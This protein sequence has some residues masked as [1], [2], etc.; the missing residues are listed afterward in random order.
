MYIDFNT[1]KIKNFLSYGDVTIDLKNKGY[2]IIDGINNCL[3]DN[4]ENNGSGKSAITGAISFAL[5]G[6]TIQ[7]L[8]SNLKN[9][10]IDDNECFV[11]LDFKVDNNHYQIKRSK[12]PKSEL[13]II[14]ND[15][16]ISGKGIRESDQIL[17]LELP[18]LTSQTLASIA[19][20]GQGLPYKFSDNTPSGRKEV[21]EKLSNSDYMIQDLKTRI[22]YRQENLNSQLTDLNAQVIAKTS[23]VNIF[24]EQKD[25]KLKELEE[26][27]TYDINQLISL[28][29]DINRSISD[30]IKSQEDLK[31]KITEEKEKIATAN[32]ELSQLSESKNK[33]VAQEANRFVLKSTEILN[34]KAIINSDIANLKSKISE[35][36]KITD[37]CPT[38]GQKLK[39]VVK[40]D[41]SDYYK[42]L[43]KLISNLNIVEKEY[44]F[45]VNEHK[46]FEQDVEKSFQKESLDVRVALKQHHD[47]VNNYEIQLQDISK[48]LIT[49]NKNLT[50]TTSKKN[51]YY[52]KQKSL[53]TTLYNLDLSIKKL[54]DEILYINSDV[55]KI[56]DRLHI[57]NQMMTLIKRDFR[58]Y[59][60][61]DII[62][63]MDKKVKEYSLEIFETELL[64]FTLN[65]NNI[66]IKY[67]GKNFE[68]L[69]GGEKQKID[70]ILQLSIR[71]MLKDTLDISSN[72]LFLDEILD[73]LDMTGC[74]KIL[75]L[76]SK[77]FTDIE[78][79][80]II[81][82]RASEL[83]IPYDSKLTVIKN[84][85]GISNI[86]WH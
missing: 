59:L 64:S 8:S 82:H 66:D 34:K 27:N 85:K 52:E 24:N 7:G 55:S 45:I 37:I 74:T 65:G 79:L 18:D 61:N 86:I 81:S 2:C 70:L 38:C 78:S 83:A 54:S 13:V 9:I 49:A 41:L 58:G 63:F 36:E 50:E 75:N 80:F 29:D 19:I 20:L 53:E 42:N 4:A 21:L 46:Y 56:K 15:V 35:L 68:N 12:N 60:L 51:N 32:N 43:E 39:D 67:N 72:I 14:K 31:I 44:D 28:I 77:R 73:N 62:N 17:K 84:E 23:N 48:K 1:V 6:E 69:S 3:T 71:D 22:T 25:D 10:N 26:L 5:T 76:I 47:L 40:P 33:A 11:E 16:D 30:L 57:I